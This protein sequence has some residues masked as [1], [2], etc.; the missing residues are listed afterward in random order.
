MNTMTTQQLIGAQ[1]WRY[2]VKAFDAT[3]KISAQT[4][5]ALEQALILSPSSYG[6]QPY[7]FLVLTDPAIR[8]SLVP[9]AWGQR[10]VADCSHFVVFTAKDKVSE[11]DV[12]H[13]IQRIAAVRGVAPDSL[14]S[15]RGMMV[16]DIVQGPRS[17]TASEWAA[18]QAYIALGNLMTSAAVLGVDA[19]P[20][21]GFVPAKFDEILKLKGSGYHAVVCCALGYRAAGDKY[22]SL[23]KVRFP[24]AELI[25]HI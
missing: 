21:E 15:Y 16:S 19:C 2:A 8:E 18:R 12:D 13:F 14:G 20:I 4:W 5:E 17:K 11:A 1:Q 3:R 10:Q 6:L 25:R 22:A 7:R 23:P 9:H 24:A